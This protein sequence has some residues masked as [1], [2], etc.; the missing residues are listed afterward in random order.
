MSKDTLK[1][2]NMANNTVAPNEKS[3]GRRPSAT[4]RTRV[5]MGVDLSCIAMSE[6]G[7]SVTLK[8][9]AT[10]P[11]L[12]DKYARDNGETMPD[13]FY[14]FFGDDAEMALKRQIEFNL[15]T[16]KGEKPPIWD[17]V[18][19]LEFDWRDPENRP[20]AA[21]MAWKDPRD[22]QGA[23]L[24]IGRISGRTNDILRHYTGDRRAVDRLALEPWRIDE[25][26]AV[27]VQVYGPI[28]AVIFDAM[29]ADGAVHALV[30]V[31]D[32][33]L[34]EEAGLRPLY[35]FLSSHDPDQPQVFELPDESW[36]GWGVPSH[37]ISQLDQ[38][39]LMT[40]VAQPADSKDALE[41]LTRRRIRALREEGRF[42]PRHKE[43]KQVAKHRK[44][45]ESPKSASEMDDEPPR[46]IMPAG[47]KPDDAP[48]A[49]V[50]P[51]S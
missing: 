26:A 15:E 30:K 50:S 5:A 48:R 3:P 16:H 27:L 38:A 24:R 17:L 39:D 6:N 31:Y 47:A 45:Q 36:K 12:L 33:T 46:S 51:I 44:A 13:G 20:R 40:F 11:P 22:L 49:R 34:F 43:I 32:R 18:T 2:H 21:T 37:L 8:N 7:Q 29:M 4:Y 35:R 42:P 23:F 10:V 1:K 9:R 14:A 19:H 25:Y 41:I 28:R